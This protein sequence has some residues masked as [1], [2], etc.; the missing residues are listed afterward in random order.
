[1][2]QK[3]LRII[4]QGGVRSHLEMA[5]RLGVPPVM[6]LQMAHDLARMGYLEESGGDCDTASHTCSG[7]AASGACQVTFRQWELTRK[8]ASAIS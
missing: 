4:Q 6:A 8:G 7:C 1:M 2:L 3:F 5:E